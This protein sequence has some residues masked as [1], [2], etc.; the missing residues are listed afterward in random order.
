MTGGL[1]PQESQGSPGVAR[2]FCT[3]G[4]MCPKGQPLLQSCLGDDDSQ[5]KKMSA[6]LSPR[7]PATS[8]QN[9]AP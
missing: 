5:T 6:T 4:Q 3:R 2:V 8:S 9:R 7:T 1:A